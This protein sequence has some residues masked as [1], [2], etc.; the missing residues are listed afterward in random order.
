MLTLQGHAI[1]LRLC[2]EDPQNDFLPST[3]T[4]RLF[5]PYTE[6]N[7]PGRV[8]YETDVATGSVISLFFDSM[9]AKIVVWTPS[10]HETL[11][12]AKRVLEKTVLLGVNTN[13]ELLGRV[14]EH[15]E[16]IGGYYTTGFLD[17]YRE[18]ILRGRPD[19]G[20]SSAIVTSL[21]LK[22][23]AE[24]ERA[25]YGSFKS[26]SSKFRVQ[27]LDRANIKM[28]YLTVGRTS[29]VIQYLPQRSSTDQIQVWEIP[30][31]EPLPDKVK[32][33]FLNKAGGSLVHRY[34]AAITPPAGVKTRE[35]SVV[36]TSF[37]RTGEV[38]HGWMV[39]NL[40][41]EVDGLVRSVEIASEGDWHHRDD[42]PQTVWIHD[43]SFCGSVK[44]VRRGM[45]TFAGRLDE[46]SGG[47]A[48]ELDSGGT[49]LAPMPCRILQVLVLE[50]GKVKRGDGLLVMESMKT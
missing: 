35:A 25:R 11:R 37:S 12:L 2:A 46:S 15:K 45:L 42:T 23:L 20:E 9:V 17:L 50:G 41:L 19:A 48:A 30:R 39:G 34:Y 22:Y 49:Y 33:K 5:V 26:I 18:E 3:G 36:G 40:T 29:F 1:E 6:K 27:T 10:R 21:T 8:R 4:I 7:L 32:S 43:P 24:K 38:V 31:E 28:D 14:L 47:S 44:V 13:Q 16:F